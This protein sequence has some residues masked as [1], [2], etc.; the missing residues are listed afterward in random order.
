MRKPIHANHGSANYKELN[1]PREVPQIQNF[2]LRDQI[3]L[4]FSDHEIFLIHFLVLLTG[5]WNIGVREHIESHRNHEDQEARNQQDI[6]QI[7]PDVRIDQESRQ[8]NT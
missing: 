3:K 8:Q 6:Y 4:S 2:F 7:I 1:L 5:L